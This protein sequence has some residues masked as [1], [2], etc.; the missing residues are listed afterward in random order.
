[1]AARAYPRSAISRFAVNHAP[2]GTIN[3]PRITT[4]TTTERELSTMPTIEQIEVTPVE[5]HCQTAVTIPP[6]ATQ[7]HKRRRKHTWIKGKPKEAKALERLALS[8]PIPSDC[9][10][11]DATHLDS[12]C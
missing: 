11:L 8:A 3:E 2:Q 12:G 7:K 9:N 5:L 10:I 4:N 6:I 1:M